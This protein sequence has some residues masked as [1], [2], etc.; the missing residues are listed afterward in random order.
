MSSKKGGDLYAQRACGMKFIHH[1]AFLLYYP[2]IVSM[3]TQILG[4]QKNDLDITAL[5]T[6]AAI[7]DELV[8]FI[9]DKYLGYLMSATEKE[10]NFSLAKAKKLLRG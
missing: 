4:K 1:L 9:E 2:Y 6:K 3:A 7:L 10:K 8:E 5:R